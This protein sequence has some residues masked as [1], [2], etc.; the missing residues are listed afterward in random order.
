M[1]L[2]SGLPCDWGWDMTARLPKG[3]LDPFRG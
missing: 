3:V 2:C 1:G